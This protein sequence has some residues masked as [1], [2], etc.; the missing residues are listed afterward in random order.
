[1]T[2][3]RKPGRPSKDAHQKEI[4]RL[5]NLIGRQDDAV[6]LAKDQIADLRM[7]TEFYRKQVNHLL[8]LVNILAKGA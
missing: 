3:K 6:E 4:D 2:V 1:M 5:K 7:E 8:A